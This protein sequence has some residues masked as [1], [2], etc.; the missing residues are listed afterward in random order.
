MFSQKLDS[1]D[2]TSLVLKKQNKRKMQIQ[3][4]Y[5]QNVKKEI[6]VCESSDTRNFVGFAKKSFLIKIED[7]IKKTSEDSYEIRY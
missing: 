3:T 4:D 1:D 2:Q 5:L 6:N 7:K